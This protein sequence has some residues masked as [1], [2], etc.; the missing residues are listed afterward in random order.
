MVIKMP[1]L[2]HPFQ[3]RNNFTITGRVYI[4]TNPRIIKRKV[5]GNEYLEL[6]QHIP[7]KL[8]DKLEKVI[9]V[10][11]VRDDVQEEA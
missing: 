10:L 2:T 7:K 9:V 8:Y 5:A 11:V 3:V 6:K 4:C 1:R